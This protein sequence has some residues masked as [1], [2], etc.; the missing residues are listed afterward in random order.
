MTS[1]KVNAQGLSRFLKNRGYNPQ[2]TQSLMRSP[3]LQCKKSLDQVS[4]RVWS[5]PYTLEPSA[6]DIA[7]AAEIAQ[8]FTEN[9][10]DVD[11]KT[12]GYRMLV[13]GRSAAPA[14]TTDA[15]KEAAAVEP[16]PA[17][18]DQERLDRLPKHARDEIIKLRADVQHLRQKLSAGPEDSNAFLDPNSD[19]PTPL[20][21]NPFI[22][23]RTSENGYDGFT[24]QFK[25]G[26]L[27][28][29]GMAPRV[30]DYLGVFPMSGNY[31]SIK[32]VRQDD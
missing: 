8:L 23:F 19:S 1:T 13:T 3:A 16:T 32:H 5:D 26:A 30:E 9:G 18:H 2:S 25:D 22:K 12:G 6:D 24:V 10:Y 11:Y 31:V 4:V 21:R 27:L 20:G 17:Q 29:Q 14:K 15:E 28:V 7:M